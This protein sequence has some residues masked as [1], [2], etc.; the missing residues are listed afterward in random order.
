MIYYKQPSLR[1]LNTKILQVK[2]RQTTKHQTNIKKTNSAINQANM[3][4]LKSSK[5]PTKQTP[6]KQAQEPTKI[7]VLTY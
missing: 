4:V 7:P 2:N 5:T 3:I 6:Q 1:A